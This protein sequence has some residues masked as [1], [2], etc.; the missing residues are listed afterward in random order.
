LSWSSSQT[1]PTSE[2]G[3]AETMN[4]VLITERVLR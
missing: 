3:T 4:A 2:N 1:E